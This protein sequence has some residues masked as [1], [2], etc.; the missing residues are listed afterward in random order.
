MMSLPTIVRVSFIAFFVGALG[1]PALAGFQIGET[2]IVVHDTKIKVGTNVLQDVPCGVGL[3]IQEVNGDWL[4][5]SHQASGWI[6]TKDVE[7]PQRA[8]EDFTKKI[9]KNSRDV[10]AHICRGLAWFN[11]NE[12]D[13]AIGD[14]NEAIRLDPKNATAYSNRA[15]CWWSKREI[16]KAISDCTNAIRLDPGDA[17]YHSNRGLL[18]NMKGEYENAVKDADEAI[19]L[20]PRYVLPH[21]VRGNGLFKQGDFLHAVE[22]FDIALEINARDPIAY[23]SRGRVLAAIGQYERAAGDLKKAVA[24]DPKGYYACNELARFYA[25]CPDKKFRDGPKAVELAKSACEQ[26]R[27]RW[28]SALSVLAAA[29]AETGDFEKAVEL[30]Q[31]AIALVP[32]RRRPEYQVRLDLYREH[33]PFH[34]QPNG[35]VRGDLNQNA[36]RGGD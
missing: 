15:I 17:M 4:W 3:K 29:H 20:D 31:R 33:Q 19:R 28:A 16:D 5:V 7:T 35:V 13:I 8:I 1:M 25:T 12:T 26:S 10:D 22:E 21:V 6:P 36:V 30:Q 23:A 24:C 32:V 27:W 2:V 34:E 14:F 11:M 18:W 9:N